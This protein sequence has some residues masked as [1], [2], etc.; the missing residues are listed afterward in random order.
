[1]RPSSV[2]WGQLS[3]VFALAL[4]GGAVTVAATGCGTQEKV[5]PKLVEQ[6]SP[7]DRG[8]K[9][10]P[11]PDPN[12]PL[13]NPA[14]ETPRGR[15][16]DQVSDERIDAVLA[17]AAGFAKI[18]DVAQQR[19]VLRECA[20]K[21]P[22]SA[23]C[24]GEMGLAMIQAKNRRAAA[25][26]YLTEAA[27]V[28]D[29]KAGA[30][31][32]ARIGEQLRQHGKLVEA[33]VALER[34]IARDEAAEYLF[35]LGQ[36]LSLQ[37][38]HLVEGANRMA[39]ARAKDDRIEWLHDEAVIRGQIPVREQAV[40]ALELFQLYVER[41]KGLPAEGLPTPPEGLK[42]RMAELEILSKQYATQAEWDELQAK[43]K[44]EAAANPKPEPTTPPS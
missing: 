15:D 41:A 43:A 29:P 1:M 12:D 10:K 16:G 38:E 6:G 44:A 20:N 8:A 23:R 9:P 27:A 39:Q 37:Q 21:T 34:A 42:G 7:F 22:P 36:V 4:A 30:E 3:R 32:Y 13:R 18:D 17:E 35:A 33:T 19:N 25:L 28:D 26:Y 5:E 24:D 40:A 14:Y 11:P 2:R 31:L